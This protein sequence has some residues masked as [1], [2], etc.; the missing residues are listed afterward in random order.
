[1]SAI[2]SQGKFRATLADLRRA[3]SGTLPPSAILAAVAHHDSTLII[4]G[5]FDMAEAATLLF[6]YG[7]LRQEAVQLA[8]FGR[9]LQGNRDAMPGYRL[10]LIT[11]TAPTVIAQSGTNLHPI[12]TASGN[13]ADE[14]PGM[15]FAITQSE[16][17]AADR[18]EVADYKRIRVRLK[19]G[20][21][22]W[23]Y[24]EA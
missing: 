15:V 9:L 18:Y 1:V 11:I 24:I 3:V 4:T 13:P 14:V 12:V 22:A 20:L 5:C 21:D 7:T 17:L 16:L 2:H 10:E 23:V 19:S 6:S 8:N